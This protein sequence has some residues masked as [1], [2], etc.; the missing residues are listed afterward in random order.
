MDAPYQPGELVY[1]TRQNGYLRRTEQIPAV[2]DGY[3]EQTGTYRIRPQ[4]HLHRGE[5]YVKPERLSR[6]YWEDQQGSDEQ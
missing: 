4:H 5:R 2:I 6:S 3:Y 1:W